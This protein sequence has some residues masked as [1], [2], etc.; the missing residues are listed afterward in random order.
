MAT[1][2]SNRRAPPGCHRQPPSRPAGRRST[3]RPMI[4]G[5]SRNVAMPGGAVAHRHHGVDRVHRRA[6]AALVVLVLAVDGDLRLEHHRRDAL[7]GDLPAPTAR[8]V[9]RDVGRQPGDVLDRE[10]GPPVDDRGGREPHRRDRTRL[11]PT[12]GHVEGP[13]GQRHLPVVGE[14]LDRR[15]EA[16]GDEHERR[17][18]RA[19][20]DG[21]VGPEHVGIGG[22]AEP[23]DVDEHVPA[24]VASSSR[25]APGP[26]S[27][28]TERNRP[29]IVSGSTSEAHPG[30]MPVAWN[31][32]PP[33]AH[34]FSRRSTTSAPRLARVDERGHRGRHDV[35]A[36]RRAARRCR[37]AHPSGSSRPAACRR[38]SRRRGR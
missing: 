18:E 32:V 33:S 27:E 7:D 2:S 24:R 4:V 6:E 5:R 31:V 13:L 15:P 29:D 9:G 28:S 8:P 14:V 21:R 19:A 37:R 25:A 35:L 11:D 38:R 34:A 12:G 26:R 22:E 1:A 20:E 16:V 23:H 30:S 17:L 10:R 3:W 36:R